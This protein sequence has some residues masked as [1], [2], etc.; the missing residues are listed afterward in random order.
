MS[1]FNQDSTEK[2]KDLLTTIFKDFNPKITIESL[3]IIKGL[4][5]DGAD[6]NITTGNTHRHESLISLTRSTDNF[7]IIKTILEFP[8]IKLDQ[9]LDNEGNNILHYYS[10]IPV[11]KESVN[12]INAILHNKVN[13]IDLNCQNDKGET[14]LYL[15]FMYGQLEGSFGLLLNDNRVEVDY[16]NG[17]DTLLHLASSPNQC[18]NDSL[19]KLIALI[20]TKK[21]NMDALNVTGSTALH[22]ACKEGT[23]EHVKYLLKGG[24]RQDIK[25]YKG[26]YAYEY[27]KNKEILAMFSKSD[28]SIENLK[29]SIKACVEEFVKDSVDNHTEDLHNVFMEVEQEYKVSISGE[30]SGNQDS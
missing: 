4:I 1:K 22:I 20:Q 26:N 5:V 17:T 14:P 3:S 18:F 30:T 13:T 25:D 7:N 6:P 2:L 19:N 10:N 24:A 15:A 28:G 21:I 9:S 8:N 12:H 11:V 29:A 16:K 27:T 23:L